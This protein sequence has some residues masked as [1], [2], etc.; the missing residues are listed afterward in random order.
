[1][2]ANQVCVYN[3]DV[4]MGADEYTDKILAQYKVIANRAAEGKTAG[5]I[6]TEAMD[7][8]SEEPPLVITISCSC[9]CVRQHHTPQGFPASLLAQASA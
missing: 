5:C 8:E 9:H 1:M 6:I 7:Q 2:T 3:C 4:A